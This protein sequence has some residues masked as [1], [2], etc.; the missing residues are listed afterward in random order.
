[1]RNEVSPRMIDLLCELLP[2]A[3]EGEWADSLLPDFR[4]PTIVKAVL[5]NGLLNGPIWGKM[6]VNPWT[7][8]PK[9]GSKQVGEIK[10]KAR[11]PLQPDIDLLIGHLDAGKRCTPLYGNEFKVFRHPRT[12]TGEI[13]QVPRT[14]RRDG[15][16]AGIGQALALTV[17]GLDFVILWHVFVAP[18]EDWQWALFQRRRKA[19]VNEILDGICD[20]TASYPVYVKALIEHYELPIGYI[21]LGLAP[22]PE[23]KRRVTLIKDWRQE[24]GVEPRR[25]EL[26]QAGVKLRMQLLRELRVEEASL[27]QE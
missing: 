6:R 20:S 17:C 23:Q 24:W 13:S 19:E 26:T 3:F 9:D 7:L 21:P 2:E 11:H 8:M 1:M 14:S 16:Y 27:T 15:Y 22:D 12:K 5:E 18:M 25:P 4:E 10:R